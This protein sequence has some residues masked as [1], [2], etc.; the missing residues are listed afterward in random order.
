MQASVVYDKIRKSRKRIV[1]NRGG[2]RSTKTYSL[3][4]HAV[5]LLMTRTGVKIEV[6]RKTLPA[7][8]AS[9]YE[10][11]LEI[12]TNNKHGDISIKD[13]LTENLTSLRYTN[14]PNSIQFFSIDN[15]QKVRSRKRDILIVPE[16]N[17]ISYKDFQ[18][19]AFRTT[20]QIFLDLNPD[21]ENIWVNTEIEQKRAA[22]EGDVDV[23][24][25][26]YT[27][28]PFLSAEQ[29][30]EIELLKELDPDMWKVFGE[31]KYGTSVGQIFKWSVGKFPQT[32]TRV[33][34]G[35]DFG[36]TNDPTAVVEVA[37]NEGKLYIKE[38][39]YQNGLTNP[40]IV[41]R[42]YIDKHEM[43]VADSAE[44]KSIEEIRRMGQRIEG[45]HKGPDSIRQS[46]DIL[47]RYELVI[48]PNSVNLLKELRSYKWATDRNGESV[49]KPIDFLNHAI[50][51]LR[52]VALNKLNTNKRGVYAIR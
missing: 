27:M 14:G 38:L 5:Y 19:L 35:L 39:L 18:Q 21:D 26:D 47:K 30:R 44:P 34:I 49:N 41:Q 51:A 6:C 3:M 23:I 31:G 46:I 17:E 7:L 8:K 52:Y 11:F 15:E 40:D 12:I 29:K 37:K 13:I 20:E 24:V 1:V 45:A 22:V 2:T 4:L 43:I 33:G 50:D 42:L 36:F 16:C 28:N 48:D 9:A 10:D 32:Y 25:S